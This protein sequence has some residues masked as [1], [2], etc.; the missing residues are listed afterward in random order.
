MEAKKKFV[1]L[2][3]H[4]FPLRNVLPERCFKLYNP[5]AVNEELKTRKLLNGKSVI[6]S[7]GLLK[8]NFQLS[9][10]RRFAESC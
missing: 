8:L 2:K 3:N 9:L 6:L 4:T 7:R 10:T 5:C 1:P